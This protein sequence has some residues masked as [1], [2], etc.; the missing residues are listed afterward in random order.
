MK[1]TLSL[2]LM[3]CLFG[4]AFAQVNNSSVDNSDAKEILDKFSLKMQAYKT[5]KFKFSYSM[6]D[7]A[8]GINDS[9][10]G[11]IYIKEDKYR[12]YIADQIVI[13]D[14]ETVWTHIKE[15]NEVQITEVDP[16]DNNTPNKMLT[17][18]D[19]NYTPKLIKEESK[20]G[21][22]CYVL[23]LTPKEAQSFYKVRIY[24]G[25]TDY[26]IQSSTIFDKNGTT[27]SY[28]IVEF[29]PNV[30]VHSSRF[31]FNFEKYAGITVIDMR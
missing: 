13:C 7:E 22:L 5:M 25:K 20:N 16:Y 17:S 15:A 9:K 3:I 14:G 12:L 26:T 1:K 30:R 24:I 6:V 4:S 29:I 8:H 23:D 10:S 31:T 27:Y 21:K 18:Y 28:S 19:E 2:L 11:T